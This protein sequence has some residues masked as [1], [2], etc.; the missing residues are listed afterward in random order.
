MAV[1]VE[2]EDVRIFDLN[3]WTIMSDETMKWMLS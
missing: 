1:T 2:R 3:G